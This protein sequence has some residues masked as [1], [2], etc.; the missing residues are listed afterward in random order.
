MPGLRRL[1]LVELL[2][3]LSPLK[4]RFEHLRIVVHCGDN[5]GRTLTA[6]IGIRRCQPARHLVQ[7]R[8]LLLLLHLEPPLLML[9]VFGAIFAILLVR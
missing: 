5:L 9:I 2:R 1:L 8:S 7:K 4:W 3:D 6:G